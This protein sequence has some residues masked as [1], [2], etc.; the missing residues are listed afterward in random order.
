MFYRYYSKHKMIDVSQIK[1]DNFYNYRP[2]L[3][4]LKNFCV[5]AMP[6]YISLSNIPAPY[7]HLSTNPLL[8]CCVLNEEILRKICVENMGTGL[9]G[10]H[11]ASIFY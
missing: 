1:V 8:S 10:T 6:A 2:V 3:F 4:P 5:D 9:P 11:T 7:H